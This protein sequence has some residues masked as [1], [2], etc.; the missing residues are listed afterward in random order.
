TALNHNGQFQ[1]FLEE[2]T[3]GGRFPWPYIPKELRPPMTAFD[4][5]PIWDDLDT[6]SRWWDTR[7]KSGAERTALLYNTISLHDGNREATADGGG[8]SSPFQTR[9]RRLLD[10]LNSFIGQLERSGRKVLVVM[11]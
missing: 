10:E 8:R 5:S 1:G 11:I 7:V 3:A 2:L 9:A 6:L 4:G